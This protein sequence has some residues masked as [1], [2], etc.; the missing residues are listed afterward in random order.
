MDGTLLIV[1]DSDLDRESIRRMLAFGAAVDMEIREAAT[2]EQALASID[3]DVR[4]VLLDYNLPDMTGMDVL[5]MASLSDEVA[6]VILTGLA[7]ESI[8]VETLKGGAHDFMRKDHLDADTLVQA[9]T[10]AVTKTRLRKQRAANRARL[11]L[12]HHLVDQL[13]ELL[14]IVDLDTETVIEMNQAARFSL[15]F[16]DSEFNKEPIRA[17]KI[18]A[19]RPKIWAE[20]KVYSDFNRFFELETGLQTDESRITPVEVLARRTTVDMRDYLLIQIRDVSQR[21]QLE[22]EVLRLRYLDAQTQLPGRGAMTEVF[23]EFLDQLQRD[24]GN[25]G[26][27]LIEFSGLDELAQRYGEKTATSALEKLVKAMT[28]LLRRHTEHLSRYG[29][30]CFAV[31]LRNID[32]ERMQELGESLAHAMI[33]SAKDQPFTDADFPAPCVG[34]AIRN[35]A[36]FT[37]LEQLIVHAQNALEQARELGKPHY[38]CL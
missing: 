32:S 14:I 16:E 21:K 22:R 13:D 27:L 23:D 12:Y 4:C 20:L 1:D 26:L 17:W 3:E 5:K 9:I 28:N 11:K 15:G 36:A 38:D 2:G 31:A 30:N 19:D 8:T 33:H 24:N 6:V 35:M 34:G 7:D 10:N 29:E 37:T 25:L 18:F